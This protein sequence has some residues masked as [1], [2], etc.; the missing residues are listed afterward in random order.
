ML[1]DP[2]IRN[3]ILLPLLIFVLIAALL[4]GKLFQYMQKGSIP[5]AP[6]L[7]Q[8][9][10]VQ[11]SQRLR[12]HGGYI[13]PR[14]FAQRI[15]ALLGDE[16]RGEGK[17]GGDLRAEVKDKAMNPMSQFDTMK[18]QMVQQVVYFGLFYAIQTVLAGFL[19]VKIPFGLTERFKQLTQQGIGVPAL[20]T[21][22]V[23]SGSWY[24][25]AQYGIQ[26]LI[27]LFGSRK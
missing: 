23:S 6:E 20:D 12:A 27:E 8:R 16:K 24:M 9:A 5:D 11:R 21:S 18:M 19:I 22:F 10:V 13:T 2:A 26:R 25:I 3:A 15:A 14:G 1:I 7:K 17:K 4:R